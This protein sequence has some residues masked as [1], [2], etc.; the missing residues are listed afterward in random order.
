MTEKFLQF[1]WQFQYFN[2]KELLTES[3]EEL[4]IIRQGTWNHNQGPDFLEASI[5]IG[6]VILVGNIELHIKSSDWQK[7]NHSTDANYSNIILHVVW[8]HDAEIKEIQFPTLVLQ[9]RIA[10]ILLQ[11]YAAI[12]NDPSPIPCKNFLPAL[13]NIGW[14]S[15]KERLA[16]ERLETRSKRILLLYEESQHHWEETFWWLLA[17]NFGIKVNTALFEEVAKSIPLTILAKHRSRIQQLEALLLGQANLLEKDFSEDYPI[18]LQ[19]E[20]RFLQKKYHL[21]TVNASPFFLRMR[22]ANFPTIRLAQLA[23]LVN[24]SLH[25][26]SKIK[27]M[28]RADE[29]KE[30]FNVT[31]NDYWHYHYNFDEETAYSPKHLGSQMADN[32][33]INTVIPVLFAYGSYTKEEA[34]KDK[35]IGWMAEIAPEKN[36]VISTWKQLGIPAVN[37]LDSQS[38]IQLKNEYCNNKRCLDCAVGNKVMKGVK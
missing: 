2:K 1:I 7:H 27:E 22:P 15:W 8:E 37:A 36:T 11:Q 5:R 28:R 24:D 6:P 26:F 18:M 20:Y 17:A 34:Y 10:K 31:C 32:I 19:K 35:A 25:L 3:G 33:L 29:V 13:N 9:H 14:L 4:H 16:A 30:L 21:Q 23:I 12:M 38:L